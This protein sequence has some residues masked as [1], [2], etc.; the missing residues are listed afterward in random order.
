[1]YFSMHGCVYFPK[2]IYIYLSLDLCMKGKRSSESKNF[3]WS[4]EEYVLFYHDSFRI[5]PESFNIQQEP[6][7]ESCV[8]AVQSWP[9]ATLG[10]P[11]MVKVSKQHCHI[12][13]ALHG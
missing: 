12:I 2:Y 1:M 3:H 7:A 5:S 11:S 8:L 4:A 6:V 9:V 10:E 13:M